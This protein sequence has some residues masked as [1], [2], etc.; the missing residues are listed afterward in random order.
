MTINVSS[1][2]VEAEIFANPK[3]IGQAICLT[4]DKES[5][6]CMR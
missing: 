2:T 1:V 3:L 4:P 5:K 6:L